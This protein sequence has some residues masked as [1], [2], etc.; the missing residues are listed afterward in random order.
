[1]ERWRERGASK[2]HNQGSERKQKE[3]RCLLPQ[4]IAQLDLPCLPVNMRQ[5]LFFDITAAAVLNMP[6]SSF[7]PNSLNFYA[8]LWSRL[9]TAKN[10]IRSKRNENV[11]KCSTSLIII[12]FKFTKQKSNKSESAG[13]REAEKK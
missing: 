6:L 8:R 12:F 7:L 10:G 4:V 1:M 13:E 3:W 11:K 5:K 2:I 9:A